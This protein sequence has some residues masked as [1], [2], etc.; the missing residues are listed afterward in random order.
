MRRIVFFYDKEQIA[1]S[2]FQQI[3]ED[4]LSASEIA[5]N[6][7]QK[8]TIMAGGNFKGTWYVPTGNSYMGQLFVDAG[9]DY[10]Y[11]DNCAESASLALNFETILNDFH[12]VDVWLNAPT[13]TLEALMQMDSRH[14]LF[15]A[16]QEGRVYGFYARIL[17]DGANDFWESAVAHPDI[18]LKDVIWA[19]HPDLLSEYVPTYIVRLR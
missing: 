2:I 7:L 15:R 19:L 17:P 16:A 9:A 8:P 3:E 18:V 4:Y 1:D 5:R 13:T 11:A 14:G 6:V 10:F 12:D